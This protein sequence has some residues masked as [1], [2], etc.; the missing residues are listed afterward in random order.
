M[1]SVFFTDE[2][3]RDYEDAKRQ[4]AFRF[5]AFFHSMLAQGV[6]LPPS[7]FESW[8]V[9]TAHDERAVERIAAA[10]PGGGPRRRGGHRGMRL[11]QQ[12]APTRTSPSSTSCGTARCTTPDGVLYGRLARL[13]PVRAGPA[14]GRPGRRAPRR[15]ATSRMSS[16]PRWSGRRRRP[17][18]SPRRTASTSGTDERLIEAA[19]VFEGKTFGVGDGALRKPANWKYLT[20]PFRPSWGEPYVDQVVR[21]MGALAAPGRGPRA[22]G[23]A[24]SAT[25]C[26]SGSCAVLRRAAAAVARPAQAAVHARLADDLHVP[27]RPD[28][29]RRL[30][31]AGHRPGARPPARRRQAGQARRGGRRSGR[32]RSDGRSVRRAGGRA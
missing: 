17:R 18:R 29:L 25:S 30:Q 20:N 31:R 19:N 21:M 2:E 5:T 24:A 27:G 26:R 15:P 8:F 14:D 7:A 28:R 22:R 11:R 16:P 10:L 12:R 4:E 3:V 1:F 32:R 23:G 6:Y 9:S 13:P